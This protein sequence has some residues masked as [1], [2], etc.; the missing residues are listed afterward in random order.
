MFFYPSIESKGLHCVSFVKFENHWLLETLGKNSVRITSSSMYEFSI[1]S[2]RKVWFV[3]GQWKTVAFWK[4]KLI[5]INLK[6]WWFTPALPKC[7]MFF[8]RCLKI[9]VNWKH[10]AKHVVLQTFWGISA[11]LSWQD[12]FIDHLQCFESRQKTTDAM[13]GTRAHSVEWD[14]T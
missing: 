13:S 1:P 5:T 4:F 6:R 12:V 7:W 11:G 9:F 2:F 10:H 8:V 14:E 3:C